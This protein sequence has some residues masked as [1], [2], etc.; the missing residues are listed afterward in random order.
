MFLIY[1]TVEEIDYV[2]VD[3]DSNESSK[4]A[5]ASVQGLSLKSSYI[6]DTAEPQGMTHM[7]IDKKHHE[8]T[9]NGC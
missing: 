5:D 8:K 7:Y 2:K 3:Y 1:T 9:F 6:Q 4:A